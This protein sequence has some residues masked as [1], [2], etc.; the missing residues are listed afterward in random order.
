MANTFRDMIAATSEFQTI[1]GQPNELTEWNDSYTSIL[2]AK[3]N[4]IHEELEELEDALQI[5]EQ[6]IQSI[7]T[8]DA[9][10]DIC[11][12][13]A[14]YYSTFGPILKSNGRPFPEWNWVV[15]RNP[16]QD[17]FRLPEI[18]PGLQGLLDFDFAVRDLLAAT[19]CTAR[20]H[21]S[22]LM[23]G[24]DLVHKNNMTKPC[25]SQEEAEKTIQSLL[26]LKCSFTETTLASGRVVYPVKVDE[27]QKMAGKLMKSVLYVPVDLSGLC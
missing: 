10:V 3:R 12:F 7:E 4:F 8:L 22:P 6:R 1:A 24:F 26:P 15:G 25:S 20:F 2:N 17:G 18:S 23:R 11:Y 21:G 9:L 27:G 14:G 5:D 19:H 13:I 16:I